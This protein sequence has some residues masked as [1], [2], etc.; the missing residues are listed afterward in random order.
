MVLNYLIKLFHL[1]LLHCAIFTFYIQN[2]TIVWRKLN[3]IMIYRML[4]SCNAVHNTTAQRKSK[5]TL[6]VKKLNMMQLTDDIKL[7][8][9][10]RI[11]T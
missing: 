11:L 8:P 2:M 9:C 10:S 7:K 5:Q 4:R 1:S 3:E 6:S